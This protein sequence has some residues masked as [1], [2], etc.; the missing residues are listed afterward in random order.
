MVYNMVICFGCVFSLDIYQT[1]PNCTKFGAPFLKASDGPAL[2][3][4]DFR[5][6]HGQKPHF[7]GMN[8]INFLGL[9]RTP[10]KICKYIC[11]Y[12]Y[13]YIE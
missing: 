11:I 6:P 13:I 9:R 3:G 5:S 2:V 4:W 1:K 7:W 10:C 8:M 12:V